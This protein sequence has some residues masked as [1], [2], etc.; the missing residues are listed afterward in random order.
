MKAAEKNTYTAFHPSCV[1]RTE[2]LNP[3]ALKKRLDALAADVKAAQPVAAK[4]GDVIQQAKKGQLKAR[5]YEVEGTFEKQTTTTR[6]NGQEFKQDQWF[7]KSDSG[8]K[9]GV[10]PGALQAQAEE[11]AKSGTKVGLIVI[12][13][14][15]ESTVFLQVMA[16][17]AGGAAKP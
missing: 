5:V 8:E 13:S 6:T 7:L 11:S 1:E 3:E 9:A 16:A 12:P 15:N 14:A 2:S 4:L 10:A 17:K